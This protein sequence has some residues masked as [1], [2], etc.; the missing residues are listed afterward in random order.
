[1]RPIRMSTRMIFSEFKRHLCPAGWTKWSLSFMNSRLIGYFVPLVVQR[2]ISHMSCTDE[3]RQ[4]GHPSIWRWK[5]YFAVYLLIENYYCFLNVH[6]IRNGTWLIC[7]Q[8]IILKYINLIKRNV[9]YRLGS[10]Y[11]LVSDVHG[12]SILP[13]KIWLM[14]KVLVVAYQW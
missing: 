5:R 8:K 13:Y 9:R 7:N 14:I 4:Y 2:G 1:M 10:P 3:T 11:F 6:L 12:I